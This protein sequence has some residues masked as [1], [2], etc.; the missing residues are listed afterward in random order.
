MLF[1]FFTFI[2]NSLGTKKENI[3]L[4]LVPAPPKFEA[5]KYINNILYT[6]WVVKSHQELQ[7]MIILYRN[8][9]VSQPDL[10]LSVLMA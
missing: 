8:N 5:F 2:Q 9:E 4:D 7:S 3:T 10:Q 6:D 1:K